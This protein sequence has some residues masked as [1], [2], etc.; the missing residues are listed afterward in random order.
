LFGVVYAVCLTPC[1]GIF[2][3]SALMLA[4]V[5]AS[6]YKGAILL[7]VYSLGLGI[8]FFISAVL[9]EELENTFDF[10]KKH[11]AVINKICGIFLIFT[12]IAI[13]LRR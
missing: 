4:S 1:I 8:P 13:I 11:Y 12:G 2:L 3:G 5:S 6:A 7:I 9:I 10:I